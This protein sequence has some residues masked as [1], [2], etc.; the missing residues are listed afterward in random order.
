MKKLF[1][2]LTLGLSMLIL[3]TDIIAADKTP[4]LTPADQ[5]K[6]MQLKDGYFLEEVLADPIIKEPVISVFDGNGNMYVAEMRTYMQDVDGSGKFNKVSRVSFHQDTNGDGKYDKHTVFADNLLLPRIVLPLDKRVIIGETNTLDLYC[7]EDTNGDGVSDKKELWYKGGNRGGNLEHQP[8]GLIWSMDNWLY[9][10]YNSY[11]LRLKNGKVI[12]EK[13]GGNGGQWGLTQ[14]SDGKP[15][16]VNAGGERGPL[17]FQWSIAY[18]SSK[19]NGEF[20]NGYKSVWPIDNIPDVQGG[21]RRIR[22]D[23]TLNHFTATC[24]QAIFRGDRLPKDLQGDLLF[25]EPVGRL[26]R[27]TKIAKKDGFS[28]LSNPYE[29]EKGEFIRTKDPNFRVVNMDTAPDGTLYIVDMYRG[30]IQEGNWVR[31]GSYLRKIVKEHRLDENFGRGRIWRL[32]HKDFKPGPQPRMLEETPAQLVKHLSHPNGW[33][34]DTAQKLLILKG[35]KSVVPALKSLVKSGSTDAKVHALWTLEGLDSADKA[36][37]SSSIKDSEPRVRSASIR[38]SEALYKAGDKSIATLITS[39]MKDSSNDVVFQAGLTARL[40]NVPEWKET[41][42][43]AI[44][45]S[46]N[47]GIKEFSSQVLK[48]APARGGRGKGSSELVK[49]SK[50]EKKLIAQGKTIYSQLCI[51]C[52]GKDAKGQITEKIKMAP[53][54]LNSPRVTGP[55][56]LSVS[57]VSHG[58]TGPVDGKNYP[59]GIMI[60][61]GSNGD[62]WLASV[63]SYVRTNFGNRATPISQAEVAKIRSMVSKTKTPWTMPELTKKFP[64]ILSNK[65]WKL[66]ANNNAGAL[67]YLID[68]SLKTRYDTKGAQKAGMWVQIELPKSTKLSGLKLDAGGSAKDYPRSYN[69]EVSND[70]KS[71]K[72]VSKGSGNSVLTEINFNPIPAKFVRVTLTKSQGGLFWS[73]HNLELYGL[74]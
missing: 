12:K 40:L 18:G 2:R 72:S 62:K 65:Q 29:A 48:S 38:V 60:P 19:A 25:S 55:K 17:N 20:V 15:W 41:L 57:I 51:A 16:Y 23:N 35:D 52:H 21:P 59:G 43:A 5:L 74:N 31:K 73:I 47:K 53:S 10:T 33:W 54:L 14:D 30:I 13:T 61:M 11:R 44:A 70:A 4:Y 46:E 1:S 68:G 26:I 37:L 56:E 71:W 49:L 66:T 50:A 69:V 58:L 63:L 64:S 3:G 42:T 36:L 7:Y 22:K 67:K 27:R 6:T 28:Y 34:R 24:G 8:S 9:T 32:R 39:A 45:D